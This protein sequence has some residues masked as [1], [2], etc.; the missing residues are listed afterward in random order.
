MFVA[1]GDTMAVKYGVT[2]QGLTKDLDSIENES[3]ARQ[4]RDWDFISSKSPTAS[5]T[6]G[7]QHARLTHPSSA[8]TAE[9][10]EGLAQGSCS[11][12]NR[13]GFHSVLKT[14]GYL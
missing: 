4:Y 5:S 9:L 7:P 13:L 10:R 1:N 3:Q 12:I 2:E 14:L 8:E 11:A 6:K